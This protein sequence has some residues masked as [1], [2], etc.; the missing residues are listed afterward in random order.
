MEKYVL[1]EFLE[2]TLNCEGNLFGGIL[3]GV[4]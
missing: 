1:G 2:I 3:F 4:F